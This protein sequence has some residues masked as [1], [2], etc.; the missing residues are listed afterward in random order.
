[1]RCKNREFQITQVLRDQ[2]KLGGPVHAHR[3]IRLAVEQVGRGI[4]RDQ[5]NGNMRLCHP[6]FGDDRRQ[7]IDGH[8]HAGGNPHRPLQP[9]GAAC[10]SQR[11]L[12]GGRAH[13]Q[14]RG[15]QGGTRFAERKAPGLPQE[16]IRAQLCFQGLDLTAQRWL[17]GAQRTGRSGQTAGFSNG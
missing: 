12:S 10:R 1:M 6:D 7:V 15:H 3:N 5:F 9:A 16:Q 13:H 8:R 17:A 2:I 14:R 11:N 4:R